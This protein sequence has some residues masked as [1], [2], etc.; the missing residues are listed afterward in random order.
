MIFFYPLDEPTRL[1]DMRNGKEDNYN[2]ASSALC[3]V[4]Y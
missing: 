2:I 3:R 1:Q 4:E